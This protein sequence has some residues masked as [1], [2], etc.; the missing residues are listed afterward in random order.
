MTARTGNGA[1]LAAAR[2]ADSARKR[3]RVLAAL[4]RQQE[5]GLRVS[6]V[7]VARE[8]QVSLWLVKAPGVREHVEAVMR[9]QDED[10]LRVQATPPPASTAVASRRSLE[11]DLLLHQQELVAVRAERDRL[12]ERLRINLG[13]ALDAASQDELVERINELTAARAALERELEAERAKTAALDAMVE[14]LQEDLD[15]A[16]LAVQRT[17]R[18]LN[19]GSSD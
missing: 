5:A 14:E 12:K 17:M 18:H 16:R 9:Q 3:S 11:T 2:R 7:S 4:K 19:S 8:A 1:A 10:G 15:A 6:W 13:A